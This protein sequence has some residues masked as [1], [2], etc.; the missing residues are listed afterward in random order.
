VSS[1]SSREGNYDDE[2]FTEKGKDQGIN[3]IQSSLT[4]RVIGLK[5]SNEVHVENKGTKPWEKLDAVNLSIPVINGPRS[6]EIK[7]HASLS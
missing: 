3:T 1:G 5:R 7:L 4:Q 6:K 2:N